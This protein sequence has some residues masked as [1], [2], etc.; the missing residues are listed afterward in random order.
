MMLDVAVNGWFLGRATTGSGQYLHHL[1]TYLPHRRP[2]VRLTV[3]MP[4]SAANTAL[5][6]DNTPEESF[7]DVEFISLALPPGPRALVKLWWE[8]VAFPAAARKADLIWVPYWAA[9]LW[10][11]RP[12]VVTVHDL[13]PQLLPAYR[14]GLH[15]QLYTHL[16]GYTARRAASI[17][18]VSQASAH[19]I[20]THLR[21]PPERIHVVYHGP[22]HHTTDSAGAIHLS[23]ALLN[24]VRARYRL[25]E[26]FFLYL[27]GFDIRK[28]VASVIAAYARYLERGGEPALQLVIAGELPSQDTDFTPDPQ[29]IAAEQGVAAHV[30]FCGWVADADKAALYALSKAFLFP[31]LYEGFG[32]MLLEA[33]AA[34]TPVITSGPAKQTPAGG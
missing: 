18:T 4:Q 6:S 10:Q 30:H 19:D 25:P 14:G 8:Q 13:I 27:G 28:N 15:Q 24:E 7:P 16:V 3:Y 22:N 34:G 11:P 5:F 29:R 33:M 2:A 32:M 17:L 26:Q 23:S 9:P 31:S 1:L 21:I 20:A 12:V